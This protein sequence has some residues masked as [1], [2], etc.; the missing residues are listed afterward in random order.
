MNTN[1]DIFKNNEQMQ[2]FY[3]NKTILITGGTGTFGT[4]ATELLLDNFNCKKIIIFSRDEFKQ[5]SMKKKLKTHK[6]F[7]ILRF[8][9]GDI[10]DKNRIVEACHN[11]DIIFHAAALKQVEA[12]EY[13]P[14]EAVK[15]NIIGTQNVIYAAK[16]NNVDKMIALSTD[17]CVSP[18]NFYGA[19]KMCLEKLVISSNIN[20]S[21]M[22]SIVRY[23]NVMSS[24]GSVIP[25][26]KEQKKNGKIYITDINMT[27]F[28]MTI[29]QAVLFTLNS[30][31]LS[32]G[33]EIFVSKIP[34]YSILQLKNIIAP[35]CEHEVIGK[36]PG[37]KL[38]E[39]LI[40]DDETERTLDV[41]DTYAVINV[42]WSNVDNRKMSINEFY[43][44]KIIE[45][46]YNS[47]NNIKISDE[48]LKN[49]IELY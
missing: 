49:L 40:S 28:T 15:T 7:S 17:K 16:I 32:M 6:N 31:S 43:G 35:D 4:R 45:K 37:E 42:L 39:T 1:I 19:T 27:R 46:E 41:N 24:R 3:D 36:F 48:E 8:F 34:S 2:G 22:F 21:P 44:N 11:V 10:R 26:F 33:G 38:Y 30:A 13:N 18:N 47:D 12:I 23:G 25:L 29:E 14:D 9:I 5:F 20:I